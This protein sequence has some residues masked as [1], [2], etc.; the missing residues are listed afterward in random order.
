M[1]PRSSCATI[2]V[3]WRCCESVRHLALY[4]YALW[5]ALTL[6]GFALVILRRTA[7]ASSGWHG[8]AERCAERL[9]GNAA[10]RRSDNSAGE[11][12]RHAWHWSGL[13]AA[14]LLAAPG[15]GRHREWTILSGSSS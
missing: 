5:A 13:M 8:A 14:L 9:P 7:S 11:E 15:V 2:S 12:I 1:K 6:V 4:R 3:P 10:R